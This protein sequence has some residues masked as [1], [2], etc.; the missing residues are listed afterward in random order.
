MTAPLDR[1][2]PAWQFR[3][4]HRIRVYGSSDVILRAAQEVTWRE[5]P[6]FR[7]L[8]GTRTARRGDFAADREVFGFFRTGGFG[9]LARADD[10]IVVGSV[11]TVSA[12]ARGSKLPWEGGTET[13]MAVD[14]PGH[15][16][17]AMNFRY[18]GAT[19]STET[20]VFATDPR[21]RR[22]FTAYWIAIRGF[23][24]LIRREWLRAIRIRAL[25]TTMAA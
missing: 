17:I 21:A 5:V 20:R 16:K 15:V 12:A 8:L 24:G 9:L 11:R 10:E 18:G 25:S 6:T 23:S 22:L 13:F 2:L 7:L 14:Q 19:L 4:R 1:V 3:E